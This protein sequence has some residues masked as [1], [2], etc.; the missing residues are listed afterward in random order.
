MTTLIID[1]SSNQE[2]L[3]GI[4]IGDREDIIKETIG[5]NKAQVALPLIE[6]ILNKH[7]LKLSD[8]TNIQVN[9]GP[10]SFTGLRVGVAIANTLGYALNI[11]VNGKKHIVEP[12]YE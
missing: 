6:K 2:I 8:L 9:T 3:I 1:T 10:G 4:K 5:Q 11:S 12:M 7:K